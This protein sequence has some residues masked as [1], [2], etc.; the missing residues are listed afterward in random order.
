MNPE[1]R[2]ELVSEKFFAEMRNTFFF[3]IHRIQKAI[4][5]KGNHMFQEANIP[6]QL[7]QFPILLTAYSV[8]GLSQQEIADVTHRDKS[9][10]QRT[11]VALEKKG[12]LKIVQ[13]PGD[14]R[15]NL[16][17]VT[18]AGKYLSEQIKVLMQRAEEA[19]FSVLSDEDRQAAIQNMRDI[20]DKLEKV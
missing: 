3:Q 20:A 16:V 2:R 4:F 12:L 19:T 7:E 11:L 15:R 17:Y 6:L 9:S 13:D 18:D 10:I 8:E 5:R 1:T 14:K